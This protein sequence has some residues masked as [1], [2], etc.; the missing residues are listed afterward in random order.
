MLGLG[1]LPAGLSCQFGDLLIFV[2]A[3]AIQESL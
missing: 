3:F 2:V 1:N